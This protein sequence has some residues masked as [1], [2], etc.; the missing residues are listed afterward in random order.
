MCS[1]D[2]YMHCYA[3]TSGEWHAVGAALKGS[4]RHGGG[5]AGAARRVCR[6][7]PSGAGRLTA[8]TVPDVLHLHCVGLVGAAEAISRE[9]VR[10]KVDEA[11]GGARA[12]RPDRAERGGMLTA[13]RQ[14][15][16][17]CSLRLNR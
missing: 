17:S 7:V 1:L 11:T 4:E 16:R 12:G 6:P 14:Q 13:L 9:M 15:E 3:D 2:A 5:A 8:P 10:G